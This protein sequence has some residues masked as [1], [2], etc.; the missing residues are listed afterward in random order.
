MGTLPLGKVT[1]PCLSNGLG[2]KLCSTNNNVKSLYFQQD[3]FH[4]I[5]QFEHILIPSSASH[6]LKKLGDSKSQS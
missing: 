4:N 5:I 6:K 1:H 3:F 2:G